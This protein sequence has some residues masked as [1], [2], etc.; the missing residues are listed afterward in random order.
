[1]NKNQIMTIENKLSLKLSEEQVLAFEKWEELFLEYNSHTNLMSKNEIPNLFE[2]HIYDSLSIV[3]WE[4]FLPLLNSKT[5]GQSGV[6]LMDIGTGGGFP[7]IILALVFPQI[8]VIAND[9]RQKKTKFLELI[10]ENLGL[11][12]L[13][14]LYGR[15]EDFPCQNVDIVTFRAVVKIKDTLPLAKA[16]LKQDGYGIFYKAKEVETEIEEAL[17]AH[18]NLKTPEIVPYSLPVD[19]ETTR[20]LVV[21]DF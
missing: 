3:L 4:K 7:S 14:I 16:H 15:A 20:N 18:K 19:I 17:S 21:F 5:D 10:K 13:Q 6:K 1:M 9:S 2:K 8:T 12:N 11:Q